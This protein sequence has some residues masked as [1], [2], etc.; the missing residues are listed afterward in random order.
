MIQSEFRSTFHELSAAPGL[1]S[2]DNPDVT[3]PEAVRK[4]LFHP[5]LP[6]PGPTEVLR[7]LDVIRMATPLPAR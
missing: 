4:L 2:T 6:R 3:G 7:M 1:W 5:G